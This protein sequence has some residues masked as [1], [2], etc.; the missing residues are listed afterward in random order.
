M[1]FLYLSINS[2]A[3]IIFLWT[4]SLSPYYKKVVVATKISTFSLLHIHEIICSNLFFSSQ[5]NFT[6]FMAGK[7]LF[8]NE[9]INREKAVASLCLKESVA[10]ALEH[11]AI[12][13]SHLDLYQREPGP[14]EITIAHP[15]T[16]NLV[17]S[18]T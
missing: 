2:L 11:P 9:A 12:I 14:P 10:G 4:V 1:L 17:F 18:P 16:T 15:A 13:R 8:A 7:N 5:P 6:H 3:I